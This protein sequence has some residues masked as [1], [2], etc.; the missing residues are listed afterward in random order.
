MP[1]KKNE[2]TLY[3]DFLNHWKELPY[4]I[5]FKD[6]VF[7]SDNPKSIKIDNRYRLHSINSL[8]LEYRDGYGIYS[9]DGVILNKEIIEN[10][11][12]KTSSKAVLKIKNVDQRVVSIKYFGIENMLNELSALSID[13]NNEYELFEVNLEGEKNKLLSMKN[14]SEPKTH[15]EWV[16][17]EVKTITEAMAWRIGMKLYRPPIAKT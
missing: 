2:F 12:N 1:E 15:Y 10:I 5:P 11:N 9:L 7:I 17:P 3:L 13:K 8:A 6:I 4:Y 16:I 14:P